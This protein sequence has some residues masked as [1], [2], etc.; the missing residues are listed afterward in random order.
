MLISPM[1]DH[2][3]SQMMQ[4][5]GRR[6]VYYVNKTYGRS[7]ALWEGRYKSC[8]IDSDNYLLICMRYIE[9]NLVRANMVS[10]PAEYQWS[11]YPINAQGEENSLIEQH[12]LHHELGSGL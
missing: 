3:I 9:L 4:A 5:L 1:V 2:G 11:S 6:Y 7:G 12:P 10:H 8:L